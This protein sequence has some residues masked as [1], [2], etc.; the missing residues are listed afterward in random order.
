MGGAERPRSGLY[1]VA[2]A[3]RQRSP[4]HCIFQAITVDIVFIVDIKGAGGRPAAGRAE[5]RGCFVATG[6]RPPAGAR[7]RA[8]EVR[9]PG[10][11]PEVAEH[12][13]RGTEA[14]QIAG[15]A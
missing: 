4:S 5:R 11:S 1:L 7:E 15:A 12:A 2:W 6:S 14:V 13:A 9:T 10:R 3:E 8:S